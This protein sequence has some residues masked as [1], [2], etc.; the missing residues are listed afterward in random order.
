MNNSTP[1]SRS[2]LPL[3]A[4]P[5]M[6]R[7]EK[8]K[9]S[10]RSFLREAWPIYNPGTTYLETWHMDAICDHLEAVTN[11]QIRR[12]VINMPPRMGKSSV[13]SVAWPAWVWLNNPAYKWIFASYAHSLATRDSVA[14]RSIILD[15]WYKRNY[16]HLFKLT[17]DTNL[18]MRFKNDKGGERI[19]SSVDGAILGEGADTLVCL[20]Y[21]TPVTTDCGEIPIGY[22]VENKLPVRVLG[23]SGEWCDILAYETNPPKPVWEITVEG[24]HSFRCTEDHPIYVEGRGYTPAKDVIHSSYGDIQLRCLRQSIRETLGS[25]SPEQN[26]AVL[27]SNVLRYVREGQE[28]SRVGRGSSGQDVPGVWQGVRVQCQGVREEGSLLPSL[29][30]RGEEDCS[31]QALRHMWTSLPSQTTENCFLQQDVRKPVTSNGYAG[32]GERELQAWKMGYEVW[33]RVHQEAT[34]PRDQA[35]RVEVRALREYGSPGGA[36]HRRVQDGPCSYESRHPLSKLP[37]FG[38]QP[39]GDKPDLDGPVRVI[40]VR[41]C[42]TPHAVYN[43]KVAEDHAYY[44]SGV[45]V[46]NCD[47]PNNTKK[48]ES[49]PIRNET[50]RWWDEVMSSRLN[51]PRTGSKVIVSQRTHEGDLSGHVLEMGGY[52]HLVLP[53]EYEPSILVNGFDAVPTSIGWVDPRK[54]PGELLCPERMGENEVAELKRSMGS[55]AAAGQLQQRPVG[56]EGGLF[57]YHW[58]GEYKTEDFFPLP[59]NAEVVQAWDTAFKQNTRADWSVC[60]TWALIDGFAYVLDVF[61]DKLE[62]PALKRKAKELYE[63]WM[64]SIV[65]IENKASGQ[66]LQ[67]ELLVDTD[68][69]AILLNPKEGKVER[70]TAVT[71]YVEAGR[72]LLPDQAHWKEDWLIEHTKF[73]NSI[74]DDQVDVSCMLLERL[75]PRS[76]SGMIP[77][78]DAKN[79]SRVAVSNGFVDRG[80]AALSPAYSAPTYDQLTR[81]HGRGRSTSYNP[82]INYDVLAGIAGLAGRG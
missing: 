35:G 1:S 4:N 16:G 10:L 43:L 44:A 47:D 26:G 29:L 59:E 15:P 33:P 81:G 42:G 64:P 2:L 61:R 14:T 52:E 62:F 78:Y 68:I 73:P 25:R 49:D 69:P 19:A 77:V 50:N 23:P 31:F 76:A 80:D 72:V 3:M 12:L 11:G 48:I 34:P 51:D 17:E 63:K 18:K 39:G 67:Q 36:S 5:E 21:V 57:K 60:Q 7:A 53:M 71:P 30:G 65:L 9:R 6:L 56:R 82:E 32:F 46:H 37:S 54:E 55:F 66:S 38:S 8:A 45:L 79:P 20:D 22:V 27:L 74:K 13:V 70:A 75:F 24:G 58:W 41:C 40:S 28:Q